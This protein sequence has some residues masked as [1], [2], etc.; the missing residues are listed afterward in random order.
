MSLLPSI[1]SSKP[2]QPFL[3]LQSTAAQSCLPILRSI[4]DKTLVKKPVILV[5]FLHPPPTLVKPELL[6]SQNLR[7]LDW[8]ARVPGYSDYSVDP[9]AEILKV[10]QGM[11]RS[12][13]NET[14][15]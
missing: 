13:A 12:V 7:L 11:L 1:I 5:C 6:Q 9:H 4:L 2:P 14:N 15:R 10:I 8:T 3:L